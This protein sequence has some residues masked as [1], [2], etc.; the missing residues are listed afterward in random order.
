VNSPAA[1]FHWRVH[2]SMVV[3]GAGST[4]IRSS[5]SREFTSDDFPT[6]GPPD[7]RD[8]RRRRARGC[9]L[10]RQHLEHTVEQVAD[11][12]A[13]LGGDPERLARPSSWKLVDRG[14]PG[15]VELVHHQQGARGLLPEPV[16][17]APGRGR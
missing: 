17:I 5:P 11:V 10:R 2:E 4:I 12:G 16:A 13:V 8:A 7:D 9:A 3:P 1:V 6:F 15:L 14:V